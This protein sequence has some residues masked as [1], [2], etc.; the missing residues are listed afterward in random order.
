MRTQHIFDSVR[1]YGQKVSLKLDRI[2]SRLQALLGDC[3]VLAASVCLL[4]FFSS[5]ERI[6]IRH[7]IVKYV[8]EVQDI[9][10]SKDWTIEGKTQNPK[11]QTKVFKSILKEYGLRHLLLPHNYSGIL[12]ESTICETLFHMIF[13]PSCPLII[14]PTGEVQQ[15]I[16]ANII[17]ELHVKQIYGSDLNINAHLQTV[18]RSQGSFSLLTDVNNFEKATFGLTQD[19]SLLH[20]LCST[21]YNG[22][23]FNYERSLLWKKAPG[24][25]DHI[26]SSF[27]CLNKKMPVNEPNLENVSLYQVQVFS[28]SFDFQNGNLFMAKGSCF[29]AMGT[30]EEILNS[31]L[32]MN[33]WT[34]LKELL[35]EQINLPEWKQLQEVKAQIKFYGENKSQ[36][37]RAY[38]NNFLVANHDTLQRIT[39]YTS[40][41]QSIEDIEGQAEERLLYKRL[42]EE[43]I[44]KYEILTYYSKVILNMYLSLKVLS[45]IMNEVTF[46][47]RM[48][49]QILQQILKQVI[50]NL[51]QEAV[52]ASKKKAAKG[53]A[54]PQVDVDL[55]FFQANLIPKLHK[56]LVTSIR[57]DSSAPLFNLIFAMRIALLQEQVTQ[58]EST[59]FF[60][61]LLL[62]KDFHTWRQTEV[63]FVDME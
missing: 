17:S 23:D 10:C 48:F 31:G 26:F 46:S 53:E 37:N 20:R 40:L 7:E 5:D 28:P 11:I 24:I 8:S 3:I 36:L 56:T 49:K 60:R 32:G 30:N 33:A 21:F 22:I 54:S 42:Y 2:N 1:D 61:Q 38:E 52:T 62:L 50:K 34:E 9:T 44:Q 41:K 59:L 18:F 55:K 27:D 51:A 63:D 16:R 4:G 29:V 15:F 35:L 57:Q 6:E 13:A 47:W 19:Q 43:M 25:G 39:E 58:K 12:P 45:K 14:D